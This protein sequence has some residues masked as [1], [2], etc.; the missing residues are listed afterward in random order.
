MTNSV[1]YF[2]AGP[3]LGGAWTEAE[4]QALGRPEIAGHRKR[5]VRTRKRQ[6]GEITVDMPVRCGRNLAALIAE[7]PQD[8]DEHEITCPRC[9]SVARVIRTPDAEA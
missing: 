1:K 4:A 2:C 5:G 6:V 7:V 9:G 3:V 8:G